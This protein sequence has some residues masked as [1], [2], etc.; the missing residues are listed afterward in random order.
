MTMSKTWL[1]IR[2]LLLMLMMGIACISTM[3]ATEVFEAR[4]L[5]VVDGNTLE[6]KDATGDSYQIVLNGVDSPELGQDFGDKARGFL[7]KIALKKNVKVQLEGKDRWGNRLAVVWVKGEVDLRVELLKAG[8]AWTAERNPIP[9]LEN[10]RTEAQEKGKG[11]WASNEPS[12]PW[13]FRRQ[14]SM[15]QAKGS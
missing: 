12:P 3:A 5:A 13:I 9:T 7:E 10:V 11:L 4:V 8:L 15:L 1:W 2:V 14:Q 6:I